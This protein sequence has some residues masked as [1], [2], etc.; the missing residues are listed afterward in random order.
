MPN[1]LLLLIFKDNLQI[2]PHTYHSL[3]GS[4]TCMK[5]STIATLGSILDSELSW[6]SCKFQLARWS[7]DWHYNQSLLSHPASQQS[8]MFLC[9]TP[10]SVFKFCAVSPPQYKYLNTFSCAVP[11][12]ILSSV[13]C[14]VRCPSLILNSVQCPRIISCVPT[15]VLKFDMIPSSGIS[16]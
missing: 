7:Q 10:L 8:T 6:E 5:R 4:N 12:L 14:Y 16:I 11:P 3:A 15:P 9:G 13:W 2:G 1:I